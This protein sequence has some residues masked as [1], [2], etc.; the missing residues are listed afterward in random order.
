NVDP[1]A[2][3]RAYNRTMDLEQLQKVADAII[4]DEELPNDTQDAQQAY[5][6][7]GGTSMGGARP[8]AVV[9]DDEGLWI[10]KFNRADDT[11]NYA[12]IERAMLLCRAG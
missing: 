9:E 1:P 4:A 2:P 12:K 3:L 5:E 8:K 7:L 10:A 6:L 11:W